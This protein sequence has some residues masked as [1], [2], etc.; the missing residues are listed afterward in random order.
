MRVLHR[1]RRHK[2]ACP[3]GP[4]GLRESRAGGDPA[5][6]VPARALRLPDAR[7]PLRTFLGAGRA[8]ERLSQ[9]PFVEDR[10]RLGAP[11]GSPAVVRLFL[12]GAVQVPDHRHPRHRAVS[13]RAEPRVNAAGAELLAALRGGA[14][15]FSAL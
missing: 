12:E 6:P 8:G 11:A 1:A 13:G 7:H 3:P 15:V 2:R 10:C 4:V 5:L 14:G 9:S